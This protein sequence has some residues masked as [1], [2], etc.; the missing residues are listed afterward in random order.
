MRIVVLDGH[1]LNPGDLSWEAI[2]AL[3]EATIYD[4]TAPEQIVERA[5]GA[6]IVLTNKTPLS[7]ST[8]AAL[9]GL[10]YIG[11][12]ATGYN[13]VDSAAARSRGIP[14]CNIP[15]YGT[16]SVAQASFALLLELCNHFREHHDAV[17]N[18]D[19][20]AAKHFCFWNTP[21]VELS[22]KTMGII[23]FGTIGQ[24][25]GDIAAAFGMRVMAFSRRQSDQSARA[26]FQ[27]ATLDELLKEADVVSLHCPLSADNQ[28]MINTRTLAL[29]KKSAFLINTARGPLI[30]EADLADALNHQRIAGA[31]L[32][33]LSVE[34]PPRSNP[35]LTARNCIITPHISWA[36]FEA[37][38][39]LM[40]TA[41]ENLKAWLA[42][43]PENVV[44][45]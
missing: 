15:G 2:N 27:W 18:G 10:R 39:R 41:A 25:V 34:P 3:G 22:G 42:G 17:K 45:P 8:L 12:L 23:G 40:H 43:K 26:N 31:A 21:L 4:L 30:E 11:V 1:T 19:W 14:V 36:T 7:Q 6:E 33:V 24:K 38:S 16:A 35:L 28:G 20:S 5:L 44:N 32:D 37:R 9:P 13:V 29:M